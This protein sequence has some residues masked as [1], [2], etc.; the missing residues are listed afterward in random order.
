MKVIP[1][2]VPTKYVFF[3]FSNIP[4]ILFSFTDHMDEDDQKDSSD[5]IIEEN[6]KENFPE[7]FP[8][9]WRPA[10]TITTHF[11]TSNSYDE[12][13]DD[14]NILLQKD[15]E[16]LGPDL[17]SLQ[18]PK[19]SKKKT[20]F[21]SKSKSESFRNNKKT[22][23]PSRKNSEKYFWNLKNQERRHGNNDKKH[24]PGLGQVLS[25]KALYPSGPPRNFN[26]QDQKSVGNG[27]NNNKIV[28]AASGGSS[29]SS[30]SAPVSNS[31]S[32]GGSNSSSSRMN[33][34]RTGGSLN[35]NGELDL[36]NLEYPDSPT[37]HKWFAGKFGLE[38]KDFFKE[39]FL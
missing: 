26:V 17:D 27:N 29:S 31:S 15:Q 25:P 7:A 14:E 3:S 38:V 19:S 35:N 9:I 13:E 10:T 12:I 24:R 6:D 37:S 36:E 23:W 21:P 33:A 16:N 28:Q 4:T 11:D 18:P 1:K 34:K 39:L 32:G 8:N 22:C 2:N 30:M 20:Q 5:A